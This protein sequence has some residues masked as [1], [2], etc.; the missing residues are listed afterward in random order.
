MIRDR[1][2]YLFLLNGSFLNEVK[3]SIDLKLIPLLTNHDVKMTQSTSFRP[4]NTRI[5]TYRYESVY[6]R[7]NLS[8][9]LGYMIIVRK[10]WIKETVVKR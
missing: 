2:H 5:Q 6:W 1:L 8:F 4:N 7:F 3:Y 10:I 9:L